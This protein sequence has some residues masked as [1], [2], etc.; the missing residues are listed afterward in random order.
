MR[1][2]RSS[3]LPWRSVAIPGATADVAL[4]RLHVEATSKAT[5]S[6]VRFPSG[7][8]RPGTGH[9]G[10]AELFVVIEGILE[11]SGISYGEGEYAYLPAR[12][13]RTDS[14]SRGGCLT[15]AWFSAPP[16]W[17]RGVAAEP[18]AEAPGHGPVAALASAGL[19]DVP[20]AM[21]LAE[22][23]RWLLPPGAASSG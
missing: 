11:V 14:R 16:V 3:E 20:T 1:R 13:S 10:C 7:W 6:V 23:G 2:V 5:V 19:I 15:V 9:Y 22:L 21:L 4:A 17:S 18:P 12:T 8:S